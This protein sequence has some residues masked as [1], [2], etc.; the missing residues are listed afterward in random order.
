MSGKAFA[1]LAKK[2]DFVFSD[3][4]LEEKVLP[5][6]LYN[7]LTGNCYTASLY[8]GIC[9]LLDNVKDLAN[10]NLALFS[11]GSGC[12]GEFFTANVTTDYHNFLFREEHTQQLNSRKELSYDEYKK[13]YSFKLPIDGQDFNC[14]R[15]SS[16]RFRLAGIKKHKRIYEDTIR[17]AG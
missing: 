3:A 12:V 16:A 6:T 15:Y 8:Q 5:A 14:P 2:N 9:S 1:R 17:S 13:F 7:R 4:Y 10:Q 11:Y